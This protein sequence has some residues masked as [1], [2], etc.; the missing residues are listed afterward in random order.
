MI[1]PFSTPNTAKKAVPSVSEPVT[2]VGSDGLFDLRPEKKHLTVAEVAEALSISEA[3]VRNL[4]EEG[5]LLAVPVNDSLSIQGRSGN[6]V[7][8][9]E[10]QARLHRRVLR[11]SAV[12]WWREN[13]LIEGNP[14]LPFAQTAEVIWWREQ[15]RAKR[16]NKQ[17]PSSN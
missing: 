8:G 2:R 4:L 6:G 13:Q 3:H 17:K 1:T 5:A 10:T 12:G 9:R 14:E 15:L 16:G 11:F 7:K